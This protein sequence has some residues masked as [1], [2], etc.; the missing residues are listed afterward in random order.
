MNQPVNKT[1]QPFRLLYT[2]CV[3]FGAW[4]PTGRGFAPCAIA[5]PAHASLTTDWCR[6]SCRCNCWRWSNHDDDDDSRGNDTVDAD[7]DTSN[8]AVHWATPSVVQS[9]WRHS[10][11]RGTSLSTCSRSRWRRRWRAVTRSSANRAK[12]RQSPP[13]CCVGSFMKQ[14]RQRHKILRSKDSGS[15]E[16][17]M[18]KLSLTF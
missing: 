13:G 2:N 10:S 17:H 6:L 18:L 14:V 12:W 5:Y 3:F 7:L 8:Q 4:R 1:T 9:A 15:T 11:A 16:A